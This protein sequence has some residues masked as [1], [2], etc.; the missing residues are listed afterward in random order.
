[1]QCTYKILPIKAALK[2]LRPIW[3]DNN[4]RITMEA[5]LL[6]A[7]SV[8]SSSLF[9]VG[10]WMKVDPS[11]CQPWAGLWLQACPIQRLRPFVDLG[12][13]RGQLHSYT[14]KP[15]AWI[16]TLPTPLTISCPISCS[17][18]SICSSLRPLIHHSNACY[19]TRFPLSQQG[20]LCSVLSFAIC[21]FLSPKLSTHIALQLCAIRL[22]GSASIRVPIIIPNQLRFS[23]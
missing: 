11:S 8:S 6:R 13:L 23:I 7:L 1:M 22:Q 16:F 19:K 10:L 20:G 2:Y 12:G 18:S 5:L 21:A 4:L 17:L 9:T 15:L 3:H 14:V